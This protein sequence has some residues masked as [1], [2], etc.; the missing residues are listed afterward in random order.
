MS[1]HKLYLCAIF[2]LF[3][4]FQKIKFCTYNWQNAIFFVAQTRN[5]HLRKFPWLVVKLNCSHQYSSLLSLSR[6]QFFVTPWTAACQASLSITNSQSLF[7]FMSTELVMPS[8][9]LILRH[10][11]L[12]PTSIFPSIRVFSN[13]SVL[14]IGDQNI[15]I[16]VSASVLPMNIQD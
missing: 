15:G 6:V 5:I 13:E 7:I 9:N 2:L 3:L 12:L 16:S 1:T 10:H 8:N 11:L 14:P 4:P